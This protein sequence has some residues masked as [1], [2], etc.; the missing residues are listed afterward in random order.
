MN[1]QIKRALVSVSDKSNLLVLAELCK[2]YNG[3]DTGCQKK[4]LQEAA[5]CQIPIR[6]FKFSEK[7]ILM[8]IPFE[9]NA[10]K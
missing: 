3:T 2:T 9:R 4:T 1:I 5:I 10:A 7:E 6:I 8:K